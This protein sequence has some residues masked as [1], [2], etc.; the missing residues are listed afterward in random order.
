MANEKGAQRVR[1]GRMNRKTTA[2]FGLAD[3]FRDGF[4]LQE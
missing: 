1:P 2:K 3:L 4:C